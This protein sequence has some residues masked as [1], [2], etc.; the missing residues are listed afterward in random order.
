MEMVEAIERDDR[1]KI[2]IEFLEQNSGVSEFIQTVL[3]QIY[4]EDEGTTIKAELQDHILSLAEDYVAAGHSMDVAI[5][6]ALYQMGD[7][8]EIGYSFTDY[9]GM[10]RR[11]RLL[12][13]LKLLAFAI[14]IGVTAF[15]IWVSNGNT[16]EPETVANYSTQNDEGFDRF[17]SLYYLVYFPLLFVINFKSQAQNGI[18]GI[19]VKKLKLSKEPLLVLWSYKRRFPLEYL[20]LSVFFVPII[21]IFAVI[22]ISEGSSPFSFFGVI[23]AFV[24]SIWLLMHSEKYRIPKYMI[25]EEGIVIKNSLVSWTTIDRIYWTK[26]Y[27][28]TEKDH[29][30]LTIEHIYRA[31][32]Q[33]KGNHRRSNLTVKR[34][35]EVN[36]NQYLQINTLIKERI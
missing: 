1:K 8:T 7:P 20:I 34:N 12:I 23:L 31:P 10:K 3:D 13:G 21:L 22:F 16:P 32:N 17:W 26:D 14:M 28:S 24:L 35:I 2:T 6:K 36:A 25:M 30:K 11:R 18:G 33:T 29:Y 27:L 9:E 19:P 5:R 4:T 15:V